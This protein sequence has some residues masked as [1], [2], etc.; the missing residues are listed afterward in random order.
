MS[1]LNIYTQNT[2]GLNSKIKTGIIHKTTILN[3]DIFALTKTWLQS[4]VSST[5]LFGE[6][7]V[8]HRSDRILSDIVQTGGGV[9]VAIKNSILANRLSD[10]EQE[11]PFENIWLKIKTN[12]STKI[13]LN[14]IYLKSGFNSLHLK[15]YLDHITDIM[16][17]REP[18]PL[19]IFLTGPMKRND[20]LSLFVY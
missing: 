1:K 20:G 9:L 10:W 2:R 14:T 4:N 19:Y 18:I 7:Y 13:F 15:Q 3:H 11:I 6:A 16:L 17:N 5:E 8:T 12:D